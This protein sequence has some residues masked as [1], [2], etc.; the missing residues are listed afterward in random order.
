MFYWLLLS[1]PD[2]GV[3]NRSL[4]FR[5]QR[6]VLSVLR[7]AHGTHQE[8][9]EEHQDRFGV[10]ADGAA[11]LAAGHQ[12]GKGVQDQVGPDQ[13]QQ[14]QPLELEGRQ[15]VG[16]E[17]AEEETEGAPQRPEAQRYVEVFRFAAPAPH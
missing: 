15:E 14:R 12:T 3:I 6:F 2:C 11:Q 7:V 1:P 8:G 16:R 13:Q 9:L 5:P 10:A 4:S 17:R